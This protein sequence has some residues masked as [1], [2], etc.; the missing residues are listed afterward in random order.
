[1]HGVRRRGIA[2]LVPPEPPA[3]GPSLFA[4]HLV[5]VSTLQVLR[6]LERALAVYA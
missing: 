2:R 5:P 6:A 3:G 1:M 4:L